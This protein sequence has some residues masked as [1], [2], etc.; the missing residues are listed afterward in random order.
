MQKLYYKMTKRQLIELINKRE[1]EIIELKEAYKVLQK[2][3]S[4]I[5]GNVYWKDPQGYLMGCNIQMANILGYASPDDIIGKRNCDLFDLNLA[6][7]TDEIDQEVCKFATEQY[8]EEKG[9]TA[10]QKPAIYL[11]KKIPLK[12]DDGKVMGIL[13]VS[14][15]ITERKR[16]EEDL[17]VAKERAESSSQ[18]KSQFLAVI[19]HELKTPLT[20]VLSLLEFLKKDDLAAEERLSMLTAIEDCTQHLM[21]LV[22]EMIN[23]S[24]MEL[25][26]YDLRKEV[27]IFEDL[28]AEIH[29]I[30]ASLAKKKSLNLTF[31]L[32]TNV[33]KMVWGDRIMLRQ[34][35]INLIGNAI[36]FTE[37]GSVRTSI[38]CLDRSKEHITLK[39]A[40]TDTGYG[41]PAD[42]LKLIFEPFQ[43][44]EDAY[45]RSSS[46]SGTGLGLAIV[47]KL[48]QLMHAKLEV[49]SSIG[50]GSTFSIIHSFTIVKDNIQHLPLASLPE[51]NPAEHQLNAAALPHCIP[52][53][54]NNRNIKVLLVE[55]DAIIQYIHKKMLMNL[56]CHVQVVAHGQKAIDT[57][58]AY[59]IIFIDINLPDISGFEVIKRI[60][61][62]EKE[63][64]IPLI[65]LT[66]YQGNKERNESIA[67]GADQF[68]SKPISQE[69][70]DRV[71]N[72]YF[73]ISVTAS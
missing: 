70:F 51:V 12:E 35:L 61:Q 17:K 62:A 50:Q 18:A 71:L 54:E 30:T 4:L 64:E 40:V 65:A 33:P 68:L 19:N 57:Y 49:I 47:D 14:F 24:R 67:A 3:I 22:D 31:E 20:G 34:V 8:I 1:K 45:I 39:F 72:H 52:N 15:D 66:V 42:K 56:G 46:R 27:V 29:N 58:S 13:G 37:K 60:K 36:K 28:F 7:L 21:G 32:D 69:H 23:F 5:P 41:I 6:N 43:Q 10:D 38:S 25:G 9:I 73:A 48:C 59:D 26:N 53:I 11:T 63:R 16:M 2:V 44:L 55:D